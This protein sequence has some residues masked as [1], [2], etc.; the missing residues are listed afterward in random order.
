MLHNISFV[1]LGHSENKVNMK[2]VEVVLFIGIIIIAC[3]RVDSENTQQTVEQ[4]VDVEDTVT[5]DENIDYAEIGFELMEVESIGGLMLNMKIEAVEKITGEPHDITEF[6]YWGAD[7]YEHQSRFYQDSTIDVGYIKEDNGDI[8]CDRIYVDNH[9]EFKTAQD[10]GLGS[11]KSDVLKA[12][13]DKISDVG[14]ENIIV[15]S[16]YGGLFFYFNDDKVTSM[17]LGAGAE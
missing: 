8:I 13:K 10:I 17:Y 1:Y 2:R 16:I 15:G 11:T 9:P 7:G 6:E 14:D 5:V 3:N 4:T 12:Y